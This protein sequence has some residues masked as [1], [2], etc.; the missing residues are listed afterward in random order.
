M[1]T[2]REWKGGLKKYGALEDIQTQFLIGVF[3]V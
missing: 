1:L 2:G 3:G